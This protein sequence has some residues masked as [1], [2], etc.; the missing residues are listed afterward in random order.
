MS[1][2]LLIQCCP[3]VSIAANLSFVSIAADLSFRPKQTDAFAFTFAPAKVSV[4]AVEK[5][6]FAL[7]RRPDGFPTLE[8]LGPAVSSA[9]QPSA[10]SS[11]PK[12]RLEEKSS[13]LSLPKLNQALRQVEQQH[14]RVIHSSQLHALL[15]RYGRAISFLQRRAIQ[16]HLP[17]RHLNISVPSRPQ[18]M[19]HRV[20]LI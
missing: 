15:F 17:L 6:L 9:T 13:R 18:F 1:S 3:A 10:P 7:S 16:L 11:N 20:I 4:C 12:K 8:S 2:R 5:S 14:L 19:L